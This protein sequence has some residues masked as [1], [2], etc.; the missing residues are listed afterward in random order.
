MGIGWHTELLNLNT[1]KIAIIDDQLLSQS[2]NRLSVVH[3]EIVSNKKNDMDLD[4]FLFLNSFE[5]DFA[6]LESQLP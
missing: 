5:L 3:I 4:G 6:Y 2:I 1:M